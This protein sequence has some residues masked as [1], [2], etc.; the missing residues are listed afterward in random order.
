MT[1]DVKITEQA[2]RDL[3]DIY[4]YIAFEQ[5]YREINFVVFDKIDLNYVGIGHWVGRCLCFLQQTR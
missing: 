4:E 2:E 5:T 3:R 1:F